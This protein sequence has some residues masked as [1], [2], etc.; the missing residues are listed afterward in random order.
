[1]T[2]VPTIMKSLKNL[3]N[4]ID[5]FT[6]YKNLSIPTFIDL[7]FFNKHISFKVYVQKNKANL[8]IN[9]FIK[10]SIKNTKL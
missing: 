6:C 3:K 5:Q 7:I 10:I 9:A 2:V 1:M 8:M 4:L